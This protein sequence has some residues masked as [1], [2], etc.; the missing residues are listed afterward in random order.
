[1][2]NIYQCCAQ[3]ERGWKSFRQLLYESQIKFYFRVLYL[4]RK[5]WVHQALLDHLSG[6][7][8]SPYLTYISAIRSKL[9]IFAA[10]SHPVV[11]K[12][13]SFKYFLSTANNTIAHVPWLQPLE[14]F[15]RLPHVC[16]NKWSTVISEFRLGCEGLGNKQPRNGHPRMPYCPVC[17]SKQPNN[18]LHLLFFCGCLSSL[19]AVTGIATFKTS[20]TLNGI[21]VEE[22]YALFI[23]GF[24]S[25]RKE[26]SK[27]DFFDRAKC[28]ND[29]RTLWLSKW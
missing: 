23:T 21:S 9:G 4:D 12:R 19:R 24:D 5:R 28:M 16:E 27:S 11:W 1:M 25:K 7:W 3:T 18:G 6:T 10:P 22:A 26:I 8:N 2:K 14:R 17:P 15:A 13:L 20:C 29:M